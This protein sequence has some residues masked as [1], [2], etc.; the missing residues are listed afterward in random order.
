MGK[1]LNNLKR[2]FTAPKTRHM[3]KKIDS[4]KDYMGF[5]K[6]LFEQMEQD[7]EFFKICEEKFDKSILRLNNTCNISSLS[8][9]LNRTQV[10]IVLEL[11]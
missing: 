2:A 6:K 1:F 11:L 4:M 3:Q 9:I 5:T 10:I 7:A 8:G